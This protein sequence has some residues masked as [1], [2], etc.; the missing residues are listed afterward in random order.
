VS[1][2]FLLS[3]VC[4]N[5]HE[6]LAAQPNSG[7]P[8][9]L[10]ENPLT[11]T[12]ASWIDG[13][14]N[15]FNW[16]YNPQTQINSSDVQDLG[17]SWVFPL[18]DLP[19]TLA[20]VGGLVGDD[21][22]PMIINGT[23]YFVTQFDEV[24]ALNAA[25]GAVLWAD[26]IPEYLNSTADRGIG[27]LSLHHHDGID[28]FTTSL[29]GGIPTFWIDADDWVVYAINA[30]NGNYELNFSIYNGPS[31]VPGD[32]P[33]ATEGGGIG[34]PNILVDQGRGILIS[35]VMSPAPASTGR[36][37]YRGWNILVNP[38]TLMWQTFCTPP[39][40]NSNLPTDPNW[41]IQQVHNMTGAEIFYPGPQYNDGVPVPATAVVNL[42]TLSATQ[43]NATLYNDWGYV[44]QSAF[45]LAADGGNSPGSTNAGWGGPWLL[46]AGVSSGMA[47]VNTNNP[48]PYTSPC[49]PG[50]K[51]WADSVLALNETNGQWIWGFQAVAHDVWDL[52]CSWWQ[53]LGN[54]TINGANTQVVWKYC[55]NGFMYE[56]NALNGNMIWAYTPPTSSV[57]RCPDCYMLNPFNQT[58][59]TEDFPN[60]ARTAPGTGVV[61][62]PGETGESEAAYS[63]SLNYVFFGNEVIPILMY[64]VPLNDTNYYTTSGE[65]WYAGVGPANGPLE[66][67]GALGNNATISAVNAA[68][69][70]LVWSYFVPIIGFRGGITVSGNVVYVPLSSGDLLLINAQTGKLIK[71]L[72]I[73]GPLNVLPSIGAT[74]AGQEEVIVP[75][76]AGLV[77][78][79]PTVPGDV[80]ALTLA[81]SS[82]ATATT[83]TT[84]STTTTATVSTLISISTSITTVTTGSGIS[85][86]VTYGIAA[87]AVIFII[88][89]G[90][91]AT[92]RGRKPAT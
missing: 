64:Y 69:G 73:G 17:I 5:P 51:L 25:N 75:I 62:Y 34:S 79:G 15:P 44:G 77:G 6:V 78:W 68:T 84:T 4:A 26:Q 8:A 60:P 33:V 70:K 89:S 86:G 24:F 48:D 19:T 41:D 54:E 66:A 35:S 72:F 1:L 11:Q 59:M 52:D 91:L 10:A 76:T 23:I 87:V 37:V 27:A 49:N 43:L 30:I 61:T 83:M 38:P 22:A 90:Y 65:A 42:K 85:A 63:P 9:P 40:P 81:P 13:N 36:C 80:V 2:L 32:D 18:P 58:Q 20:P 39:Q 71:D 45:C 3:A 47:F 12:T 16:D 50:P 14:G 55:K 88:I 53:G 29:F 46:G 57:P 74:I 21:S 82:S 56:L 67:A 92:T 7:A 31:T 28:Q